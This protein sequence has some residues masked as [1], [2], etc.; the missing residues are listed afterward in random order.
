M[1]ERNRGRKVILLGL[2]GATFDLLGPWMKEGILPNMARLAQEG[3]WGE[4]ASTIPPTTP[5][6]WASCVTGKNPGKHGIF[7]FRESFFFDPRRPLIS[8][9]SIKATRLWHLLGRH[10]LKSAIVNVP[11]TYPPE[12]LDGYMISGLMTP[13]DE[14]DYAYPPEMKGKLLKAIGD[15]VVNIDIPKY[16]V[17]I[18]SDALRFF[19][20]IRYSFL[21]RKEAFFHLLDNEPWDFFMIVFIVMD[22]IQHLFWKYLDPTTRFYTMKIAPQIRD[23]VIECYRDVD[24]MFGELLK[25]ID[26]STLLLVMSDHGFGCT[27][28]WFN[29]NRWAVDLGLLTVRKDISWKKSLFF[30]LMS[31]NDSQFV[32]TIIPSPV[33]S[34][35]RGK[36]RAGRSTFVS[37][38]ESTID[39]EKTRA[40]FASIPCQGFYVNVK[41]NGFGIVDPGKEYEDTRSLIREK[42]YELKDPRSGEKIVDK[43]YFREEIYQGEQTRLA[44]DVLF[45]AKEYSYLG[46]QLFGSKRAIETSDNLANGFHRS[47]GILMAKGD[48][49]RTGLRLEGSSIEDITP[50]I[51][52]SLGLPLPDDMDGK[53]LTSLF[54]EDFAGK[55]TVQYR[56][57]DEFKEREEKQTY[58]DAEQ[59]KIQ[60]RLKALGYIE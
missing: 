5:P 58:S 6:A 33:Q 29:A 36:I 49:Y 40:F 52:Y 31:W 26:S 51:L 30:T 7:D 57:A 42:L 47:N 3:A 60:A 34:A 44:P 41:R 2:D 18:Y 48:I 11:L 17:E 22:R 32:K 27:R 23:R 28:F 13:S 1:V 12:K 43:V 21:K 19:K 8:L 10:G 24:E 39:W 38:V 54:T 56:P 16:D 53:I 46:R 20:D 14:S 25:K 9:D 45:V 35:I 4:L 50:T 55:T 37:D 15:Y 59:E